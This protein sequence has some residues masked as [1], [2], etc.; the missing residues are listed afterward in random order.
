M[1]TRSSFFLKKVVQYKYDNF[2]NDT[3]FWLFIHVVSVKVKSNKEVLVQYK[4]DNFV[5]DH[6]F[7]FWMSIFVYVKLRKANC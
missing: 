2:V 4:S 1:W 7:Y 3:Y 6:Y 5:N